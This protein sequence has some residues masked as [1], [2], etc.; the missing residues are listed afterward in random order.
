MIQKVKHVKAST[1]IPKEE[2]DE[3]ERIK[4]DISVSLWIK[5]AIRKALL[6]EEGRQATNQE[7]PHHHQTAYSNTITTPNNHQV[8]SKEVEAVS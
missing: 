2:Y 8:T 1:W 5:R 3:I 7:D 4:G 6:A